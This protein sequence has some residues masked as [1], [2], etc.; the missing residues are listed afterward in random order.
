MPL[1]Q[2]HEERHYLLGEKE[3]KAG[4]KLGRP[5]KFESSIRIVAAVPKELGDAI[6]QYCAD[7]GIQKAE[8]FRRAA[9]ALLNLDYKPEFNSDPVR[10]TSE[11]EEGSAF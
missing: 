1:I 7:N 9:A 10:A 2:E 5:L 8:F 11:P 3:A 4:A 6:A